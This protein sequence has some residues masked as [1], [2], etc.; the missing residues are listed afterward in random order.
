MPKYY[1]HGW[2]PEE[3]RKL[4]EIMENGLKQRKK[5]RELFKEAAEKLG[6]TAYSCQNRWYDFRDNKAV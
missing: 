2:T 1:Y 5:V 4:T 3:D 6:R